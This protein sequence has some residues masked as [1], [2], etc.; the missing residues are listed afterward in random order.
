M[1]PTALT[2]AVALLIFIAGLLPPMFVSGALSGVPANVA[3]MG[4]LLFAGIFLVRGTLPFVPFFR[5][6]HSQEPFSTLDQRFYGPL[7][8][9]IGAGCVLILV[10]T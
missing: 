4:M 8:L 1:P 3:W 10:S 7:C 5:S 9:A 2:V 6:R